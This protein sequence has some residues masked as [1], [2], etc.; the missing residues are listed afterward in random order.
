MILRVRTL[1]DSSA[2][3][4]LVFQEHFVYP[5][6]ATTAVEMVW[7]LTLHSITSNWVHAISCTQD[8]HA[9]RIDRQTV[10]P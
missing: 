1:V 5:T 4:F 6:V 3:N 9:D 10:L 8:A 7:S 2:Y